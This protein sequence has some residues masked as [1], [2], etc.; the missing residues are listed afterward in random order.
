MCDQI[1]V[2]QLA[3]RASSLVLFALPLM[4]RLRQVG[5]HVEALAGSDDSTSAIETAGFPFHRWNFGHTFNPLTLC[6]ARRE[7]SRFLEDHR[8][9]IIHTHCSFGGI[10]ANPIAYHRTKVL[11]YTQHGFYVHDG[12]HP[13]ARRVWLEIEK[14]GLR[15]AHKVICVSRAEENLA[16]TLGVGEQEK[17]FWVPGAGVEVSKFKLPPDERLE[18]RRAL[19]QSLGIGVNE[20]VALTVSRLTWDKGYAEMIEAAAHLKREGIPVRFLAAGSGK[21]VRPIEK[22]VKQ[23]GLDE[24]FLLLG[25]RDDVLDLYSAADVFVFASHREGLPIAP[26]EAMASGLPV[27]ASNI[28]G[29]AEEIEHERSGLLFPTRDSEALARCLARVMQDDALAK[30]LGEAARERAWLFD[31]NRVLDMQVQLYTSLAGQL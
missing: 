24:D 20:K 27:V 16:L 28:P 31:I 4:R 9:D 30:S 19:R 6:N 11:I 10:I 29:C 1:R 15:W 5:F 3:A 13:L 14:V 17:F 7:L 21:D 18:R 22:A 23:A 2:L 8:F 26:I 25:W 12:L